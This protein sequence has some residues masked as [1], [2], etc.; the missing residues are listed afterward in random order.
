VKSIIIYILRAGPHAFPVKSIIIYI[1]RAG[2]HA[3][4]HAFPYL[5]KTNIDLQSLLKVLYLFFHRQDLLNKR[6]IGTNNHILY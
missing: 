1:L 3:F 5:T 2:P 4:P 6:L